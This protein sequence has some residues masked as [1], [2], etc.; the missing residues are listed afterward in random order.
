MSETKK[1]DS[2]LSIEEALKTLDT[3]LSE[4]DNEEQTLEDSFQSYQ[5]GLELIRLCQSKIDAIEKKLEVL[6]NESGSSHE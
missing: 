3:I 2:D 1:K 4:M 6:E 5:K